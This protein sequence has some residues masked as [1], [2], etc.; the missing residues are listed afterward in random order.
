MKRGSAFFLKGAV[1]LIGIIVLGLCVFVLPAI[2]REGGIAYLPILVGMYISA[3]PFFIALYH[4]MKLL[5]CLD[6]N[7]AFSDISV[8]A[9][10]RIKFCAI[11]ITVVYTV[12]LPI[13]YLRAE[14]DDAPGVLAIGFII[15]FASFVTATFAAVLQKL[16]QNAIDIQSENELTV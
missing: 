1:I 5:N 14:E 9:L 10:K 16:L 8:K 12:L 15:V 13:I 11:L 6:T 7:Q 2:G 4:A 3:V